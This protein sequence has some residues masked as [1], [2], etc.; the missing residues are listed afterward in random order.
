MEIILVVL[1]TIASIVLPTAGIVW[2]W[3]GAA[4]AL[5]IAATAGIV[6][7]VTDSALNNLSG[8]QGGNDEQQ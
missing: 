7:L 6:L 4:T 1:Y 2:V 8:N 3:A 5:R